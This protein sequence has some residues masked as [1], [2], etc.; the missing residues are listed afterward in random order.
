[1]KVKDAMSRKIVT[2]SEDDNALTALKTL[3]KRKVSGAPVLDA[4]GRLVGLVTEFDLLL[5]LDYIGEGVRVTKIMKTEIVSVRPDTPL[6]EARDLFL[7]HQ[8]RRVPVLSRGK[9]VGVLS[10]RDLLRVELGL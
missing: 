9:V 4:R 8:L 3:V 1:M 10:R 6:A 5:A 2:L 7:R